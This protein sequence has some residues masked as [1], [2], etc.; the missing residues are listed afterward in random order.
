MSTYMRRYMLLSRGTHPQFTLSL[1]RQRLPGLSIDYFVHFLWL[2][3]LPPVGGCLI[4]SPTRNYTHWAGH[5]PST[6]HLGLLL[7]Q[8]IWDV[9]A[10]SC[11]KSP[12]VTASC[13]HDLQDIYGSRCC[14]GDAVHLPRDLYSS[15]PSVW[16]VV[17]WTST[18]LSRAFDVIETHTTLNIPGNMIYWALWCSSLLVRCFKFLTDKDLHGQSVLLLLV[19]CYMIAQ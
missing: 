11:V 8:A 15:P 4:R 19:Y 9:C 12:A 10:S 6:F 13:V 3:H 18:W 14:E 16:H 17:R 2:I 1:G 7:S 5:F